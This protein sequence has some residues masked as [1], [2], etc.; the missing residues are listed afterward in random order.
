MKAFFAV[1]V[2]ASV[3]L[4]V[5]AFGADAGTVNI[6][7]E[8][9]KL[10]RKTAVAL[11]SQIELNKKDNVKTTTIG[12]IAC[13]KKSASWSD[14]S[15]TCKIATNLEKN[16]GDVVL[17]DAPAL[18][19]LKTLNSLKAEVTRVAEN[20]DAELPAT[21]KKVSIGV[22]KID[23]DEYAVTLH[24]KAGELTC[25]NQRVEVH[26]VQACSLTI[27]A[28]AIDDVVVELN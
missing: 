2:L 18:E 10:S 1:L 11:S 9:I 25:K 16:K 20:G 6:Y 4:A 13:S 17:K 15:V 28:I 27:Q 24:V 21:G 12:D 8:K 7:P 14:G 19:L 5:P 22:K 23:M 3:T 26:V